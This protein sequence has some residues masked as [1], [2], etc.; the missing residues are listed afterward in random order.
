[1]T[2]PGGDLIPGLVLGGRF[3]LV[4]PLA[5]GGMAEVW[6][7]EDAVLGRPVAV[8]LLAAHLAADQRFR[9]RFRREAIAAA[10]LSHPNIVATYDTGVD[11][12]QAYIVMELV[13]GQTLRQLLAGEEELS[14]QRAVAIGADVA[15]ALDYAHRSGVI[16][17]DVKPA[18]I[19][20]RHDGRVK[21]VDF[22]IAKAVIASGAGGGDHDGDYDRPE[23]DLTQT[24]T[25]LGTAKYISPEQA[26][27]R[28]LD[29]RCDIYALGVVLFE[30][31]CGRAPF[32]AESE[33]A[34][35]VAHLTA[36]VPIP[37]SLRPD[38][39]PAL[40]AVVLR[41]LAKDP[42]HRFPD[43]Q[44]MADALRA[45]ARGTAR[46]GD[47]VG[48]PAPSS[49]EPTALHQFD[50][51][52][53]HQWSDLGSGPTQ[54]QAGAGPR[55]HHKSSD[56]GSGPT[57]IQAGAGPGTWRPDIGQPQI[58]APVGGPSARRTSTSLRQ[59]AG[60]A[61]AVGALVAGFAAI[62]GGS[63]DPVAPTTTVGG[64][65]PAL[66]IAGLAAF[67][68]GGDGAEHDAELANLIDGDPGTTW[69]TQTYTNSN[70]G[71]LKEGVGVVIR[72]APGSQPRRLRIESPVGGW[73]AEV[74][75]SDS[76][77]GDRGSWGPAVDSKTVPVGEA[78]FE[79]GP[80]AGSAI[81]LWITNLG[82]GQ[83]SIDIGEIWVR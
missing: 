34:L 61:L 82:P 56:P 73:A 13:E 78:V 70:F 2:I 5:R 69:G 50:A 22:G 23:T 66:E 48:P 59:A 77:P 68:P 74:A 72:L 25:V 3:R 18:N 58:P 67:D 1:M 4:E 24:G 83:N 36:P 28:G 17:R 46:V 62:R 37:S 19:L 63:Q 52:S 41:A 27:G 40:E 10:R 29:G 75:T 51:A 80:E 60:A 20:L 32:T 31:L 9:I 16:H 64:P 43:A 55:P 44:A 71:N 30:M 49:V 12:G 6:K 47:I 76:P 39:E 8:K 21:V 35:G 14:W 54:I 38:L 11:D 79:L 33:M 57:R 53:D 26:D 45:V 7:A 81:L 15:G 42:D 65:A